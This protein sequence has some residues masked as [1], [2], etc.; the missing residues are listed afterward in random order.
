MS[1]VDV[2]VATYN[3]HDLLR[4]CLGHLRDQTFDQFRLIVVDDGSSPPVT[5]LVHAAFPAA[6]VLRS[7]RNL[8][9]AR[10]LNAGIAVGDSKFV[11]L[12]NDDTQPHP[13]WLAE[14]VDCALRHPDAGS[15]ASKLRLTSERGKLH[16]AGDI[17]SVRAMPGN[18]GVW[19]DDFGQYDAA[20]EVFGACGG[21]ALYR[22][23]ALEAV[24]LP[25]GDVFDR[26]LFMYCEDVDLAWRLQTSGWSCVF[27]PRAV[28]DHQLSATGGG[29]LASYYVNRNLWL[30]FA[31]S[32][33]RA[34]FRPYLARVLPFHAGRLLRNLRHAREP[35]ARAA[36]RGSIVGLV[37][38]ACVRRQRRLD[39]PTLDRLRR[40]LDPTEVIG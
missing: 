36:L 25:S 9:L 2:I 15:I 20:S 8:G 26:R 24:R 30:V 35:A 32:V 37:W 7:S 38:L 31:R 22:R 10:G 23:S 34:L 27:A 40:V 39:G 13:D 18:R 16:S 19:L 6:L 11:V 4:D 28:V 12:L 5:P 3:G 21:A 33:P 17:Y 1:S 14:L 29:A